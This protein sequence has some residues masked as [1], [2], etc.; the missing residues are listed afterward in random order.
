[1]FGGRRLATIQRCT[2]CVE[3]TRDDNQLVISGLAN[4][5]GIHGLDHIDLPDDEQLSETGDLRPD[6]TNAT[7]SGLGAK[8]HRRGE[9]SSV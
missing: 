2:L 5:A 8:Q 3:G 4:L 6:V 7:R 1:M 9:G